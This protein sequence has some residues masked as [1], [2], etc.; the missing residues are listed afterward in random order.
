LGEE[1]P[2]TLNYDDRA[3]RIGGE[4][5]SV[6]MVLSELGEETPDDNAVEFGGGKVVRVK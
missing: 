3:V 6:T 4:A 5:P 2:S 1:T